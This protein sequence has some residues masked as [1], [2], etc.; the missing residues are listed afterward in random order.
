MTHNQINEKMRQLRDEQSACR[1]KV[2]DCRVEFRMRGI[3][4]RLKE[5]RLELADLEVIRSLPEIQEGA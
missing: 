2:A 4:D 5:I 1:R 3:Q